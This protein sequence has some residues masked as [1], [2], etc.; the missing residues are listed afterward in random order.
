M[1]SCIEVS[2]QATTKQCAAARQCADLVCALTFSESI[3]MR[4][5]LPSRMI[6]NALA[7]AEE[8]SHLR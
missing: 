1:A 4:Q 8:V 6:D 2:Q 7:A 3:Q 5:N